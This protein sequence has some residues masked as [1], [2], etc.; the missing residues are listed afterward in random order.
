VSTQS[1]RPWETEPDELAWTVEGIPFQLLILRMKGMGH[2]CGYVG[3]TN[4]HHLHGRDYDSL[5]DIDVHGGLTFSGQRPGVETTW[6]LGF[7]CAHHEDLVP[8]LGLSCGGE[9]RTIEWVKAETERLAR[10]LMEIQP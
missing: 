5:A 2:L 6:W 9:Y 3:V 1:N 4:D 8:K 10:Q 7:D